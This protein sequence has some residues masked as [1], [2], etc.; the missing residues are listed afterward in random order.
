M[1]HLLRTKGTGQWGACFVHWP[2][3]ASYS[4]AYVHHFLISL[5]GF[6]GPVDE[7]E[8]ALE[9]S[10][11]NTLPLHIPQ[12]IDE[13][14][15]VMIDDGLFASTQPTLKSKVILEQEDYLAV[16]KQFNMFAIFEWVWEHHL[17]Q[18]Q[19]QEKDSAIMTAFSIS[20]H[21]IDI[22]DRFFGL[23]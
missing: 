3:P 12:T 2:I 1:L 8:K 22:L 17:N 11:M 14:E 10:E 18:L 21:F 16:L 20:H 19:H 13:D 23:M 9:A 4:V 15:W 5:G 7:M 6:L